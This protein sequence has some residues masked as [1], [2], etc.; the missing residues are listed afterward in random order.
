VYVAELAAALNDLAP[1]RTQPLGRS[2]QAQRR[3]GSPTSRFHL[4]WVVANADADARRAGCDLVHYTNAVA[5]LRP[6]V[7]FVVTIHDVSVLRLPAYHPRRRLAIVPFMLAAARR[8]RYVI[9][10]SVATSEEVRRLL[11]VPADRISV[12]PLAA[13]QLPQQG[14]RDTTLADLRLS[15]GGYV[16]ALG[17]IEPRKNHARLLAAFER[18]ATTH[19][20]L[21]LAIV[22]GRGWRD[23]AFWRALGRSPVR[24]RV[25]V[26]GRHSDAA[27][28]ALLASCAMLAYPSIYEGFG[29]P[30]LEAMAAGAP[31]VTSRTSSMI[32]V[33]GDA[34]VLVDPLDPKS[35][36]DGLLDALQR[37]DELAAAGLARVAGRTWLDVGRETLS[38][39]DRALAAR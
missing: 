9:V 28:G 10:P 26:T 1:R 25:I 6:R 2:D 17:T 15:A 37:R 18:I 3:G 12:V 32:E 14:P 27:I 5:P 24:D 11:H 19:A 22:G 38:V 7:P 35:I 8:A 16:L 20:D 13:R 4:G 36:A 21:C 39:Y 30:I 31:V 34:A 29:L 33:A 23:S